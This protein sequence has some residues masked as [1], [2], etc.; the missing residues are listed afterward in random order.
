MSS[1]TAASNAAIASLSRSTMTATRL[2]DAGTVRASAAAASC[3]MK[4]WL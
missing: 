4:R 3:Y 1:G 2:I